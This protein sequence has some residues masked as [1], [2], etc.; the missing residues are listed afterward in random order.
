MVQ[1]KHRSSTRLP[2]D[3]EDPE[4]KG[5]Q[6][7]DSPRAPVNVASQ[8]DIPQISVRGASRPRARGSFLFGVTV[9]TWYI[10]CG[11]STI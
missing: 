3:Q 8:V 10:A 9:D 2:E 7:R 5:L 4:G 6:R 1:N 11:H